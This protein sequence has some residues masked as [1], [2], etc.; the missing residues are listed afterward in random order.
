M[1]ALSSLLDRLS[2]TE[3]DEDRE[4]LRDECTVSGSDTVAECRDRGHHT[5]RGVLTSV[6]IPSR[7]GHPYLTAELFD[8]TGYLT[9]VWMGRRTIP[10][11]GPGVRMRATGRVMMRHGRPVMFNPTFDVVAASAREHEPASQT[12][13]PRVRRALGGAT[14]AATGRR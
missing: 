12:P 3:A 1:S 4:R 9:L 14:S 6:T 7:E 8:G 11:I 2:R 10:G 5:C 13:R